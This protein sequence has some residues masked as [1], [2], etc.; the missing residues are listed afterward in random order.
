MRYF[1]T[2]QAGSSEVLAPFY[3]EDKMP[4]YREVTSHYLLKP[5]TYVVRPTTAEDHPG[6]PYLMRCLTEIGVDGEKYVVQWL[7][8][9]VIMPIIIIIMT[10]IIVLSTCIMYDA[11]R[12]QSI[13]Q[14][15]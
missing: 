4:A 11:V 15:P 3:I 10:M 7:Q 13:N 2:V 1:P 6:G 8:H 12:P 14:N 5:G 9:V